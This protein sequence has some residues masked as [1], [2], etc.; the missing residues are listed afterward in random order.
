VK[1]TGGG[2]FDPHERN[3]YFIAGSIDRL[4]NASHAHEHLL[5]AVNEVTSRGTDHMADWIR[6]GKKVFLDSG[7]FN[8]TN[9]HA[10]RHGVRMDQALALAPD[11]IDGFSELMKKYLALVSQL[12]GG[13]WGYIELDQGGAENKKKTRA[14]L[15]AKGLRPIPVYHPL[16]DGWDYFDELAS[17]YDRI[18]FG[19]VVQADPQTRIRL[20]ATAFE[21]MRRYPHLWVHLLGVTAGEVVYTYPSSSCD[22]STWLSAVR[23][24]ASHRIRCHGTPFALM[25]EAWAYSRDDETSGPRGSDKAG[26][27]AGYESR[28]LHENWRAHTHAMAEAGLL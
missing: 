21:R 7:I 1:K 5:I 26:E 4:E 20:V 6:R 22:S 9:E 10:R 13:L 23:W 27:A 28:F 24:T 14:F 25:G 17:G 18:C 2:R 19:N 16:N 3:V 15:E 12:E 11:A 8:L